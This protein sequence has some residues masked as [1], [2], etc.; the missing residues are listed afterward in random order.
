[1][2]GS[3]EGAFFFSMSRNPLVT[4]S[5]SPKPCTLLG[6]GG[7]AVLE[8]KRYFAIAKCLLRTAETY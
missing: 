4:L 8:P 1:M 3:K 2:L 7:P 6:P 5:F